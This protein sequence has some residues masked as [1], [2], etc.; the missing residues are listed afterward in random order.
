MKRLLDGYKV[1]AATGYFILLIDI[2]HIGLCNIAGENAI[3]SRSLE[4]RRKH[5]F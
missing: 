1:T 2:M 3:C 5:N 4:C